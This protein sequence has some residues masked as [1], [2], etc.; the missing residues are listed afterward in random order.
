MTYKTHMLAGAAI[1]LCTVELI[2][3]DLIK[4]GAYILGIVLGSVLPDVDHQN[5]WISKRTGP[6]KYI[7][8]GLGHRGATHSLVGAFIALVVIILLS[9]S[10]IFSYGIFI[11][12]LSHLFIDTLTPSGVNWFW[13]KKHRCKLATI[14][15]NSPGEYGIAVSLLV[16]VLWFVFK[17]FKV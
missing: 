6:L 15:T 12:Y 13:P 14:S 1:G 5:S 10:N 16:F 9:R 7:F 3:V 8:S 2:D 11:G 17:N 4:Q